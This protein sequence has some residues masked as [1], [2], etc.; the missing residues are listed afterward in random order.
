MLCEGIAAAFLL[1][2][3]FDDFCTEHFNFLRLVRHENH[4]SFLCF[5]AYY[6]NNRISKSLVQFL[7][8]LVE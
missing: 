6:F 8:R 1:V 4:K 5:L 7:C 2:S 3:E